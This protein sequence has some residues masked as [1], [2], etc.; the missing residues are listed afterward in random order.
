MSGGWASLGLLPELVEAVE[1]E[2][3]LPT[4]I[5]DESIP[6][7]LGGVDLM[8]SA[9]TGSG[10]TA[11]F[12]LPML[13]LAA[14]HKEQT[15][16]LS[17][18]QQQ[19]CMEIQCSIQDRDK[20]ISIHP[21]NPC[22][23]Q[24]R[25]IKEWAGAKASA[26]INLEQIGKYVWECHVMDDHGIV[27][28]G[29]SGADA[30][31]ELGSDSYGFGF[32]GTGRKVHGKKYTEYPQKGDVV[33]YGKG[34][35]VACGLEVVCEDD[36]NVGKVRFAK[37]GQWLDHAFDVSLKPNL[38]VLFPS[39]CLKN[40]ECEAFF[41][42]LRFSYEGYNSLESAKQKDSASVVANPRDASSIF[43]ST[44]REKKRGPFGIVIEP[45]RDLAQQTFHFFQDMID[46]SGVNVRAALL[47][48]GVKTTSTM[49]KIE[50][51]KVDILVGTPPI[52]ASNVQ[53]GSIPVCNCRF[54]ALDE[55]DELINTDSID[56]IKAIY[57]RLLANS[58]ELKTLSR[59]QVCFFSATLH[60]QKVQALA[61]SLC[62]R[63]MWVDLRGSGNSSLP[64]TVHHWIVKVP[65]MEGA[66]DELQVTT[67]GVHRR[68]KLK[69]A[70][71]W[72]KLSKHEVDSERIKLTKPRVL[73]HLLDKFAVEQVL[74]F[75]RTNLDCDL[76][77]QTLARAGGGGPL[78][79]YSCRVLAGMRSMQ[80]R[81]Q[82]LKDF[83]HGEVRILI[84]TDVAARGIDIRELPV[85]INMTLPD[86]CPET[87]VHRCGRVGRAERMGL[88]ISLVAVDTCDERVWFCRKPNKPPCG[89]HCFVHIEFLARR[90]GI[91]DLG[92]LA[93]IETL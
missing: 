11:A 18:K 38:T 49:N 93:S 25:N 23:I 58:G 32:G 2:W 75:C 26:G 76:L 54:L 64:D 62:H 57:A 67:D 63:P 28:C 42:T 48:G 81:E 37:N 40:A 50:Q 46:R 22:R 9:Q 44:Q 69:Q 7:L 24:S 47:V 10:K 30:S 14:E 66:D 65:P 84:A 77:E 5:Q 74:I 19:K 36:K 91:C 8:G 87:Y 15:P 20:S 60:D 78:S 68:G 6:L 1:E 80:E 83:K 45:T 16:E 12:G 72:S 73:V 92:C 13:Q 41:D 4:D 71:D 27:R 35:I 53:R 29:W 89:K 34:D 39:L 82:A 55:A 86:R 43:S 90:S 59:L 61:R 3:L 17:L 85:C 31:L 70:T 21:K 88:A 56:H 52:L 79:R 51:G 33:T